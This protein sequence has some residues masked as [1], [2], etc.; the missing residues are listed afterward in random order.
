[1]NIF[2]LVNMNENNI[3]GLFTANHEKICA[4]ENL[5]GKED[6]LNVYSVQFYD[7]GISRILKKFRKKK[8][9]VNNGPSFEIDGRIYRKEYLKVDMAAR[10]I[11][12]QDDD[13]KKYEPF[14]KAHEKEIEACDLVVAQWGYPHGRL[15]YHIGKKFNKPYFVQYYGSDI[16][17]NPFRD[18]NVRKKVVEVLDNAANNFFVSDV[19]RKTANQL[20]WNKDN[21]SLTKNGVN[22]DKFFDIGQEKKDQ[23]KEK[24]GIEKGDTVIG[25]VGSLTEVKRSDK[26]AE[27]FLGVDRVKRCKYLLVGGGDMKEL[28]ESQVDEAGLDCIFTGNVSIEEVNE[29]LNIMD[30]MVLPSR[31]EGFGSVIVE[32]NSLGVLAIG[33]GSGGIPEVIGDDEYIVE[34][35]KDFEDRY[36]KKILAAIEE[37]WDKEALKKRTRLEYGWERIARID[38]DLIRNYMERESNQNRGE[39]KDEK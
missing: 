32:A 24:L 22:F 13:Y 8:I 2:Y 9:F 16:H 17:T 11:E 20:G 7:V 26:L 29:Y 21:Y 28:V 31:R 18:S 12:K 19:L 23:L 4:L 1:M 15:A 39:F 25:Y 5:I 10:R 38:L 30:I 14:I 27:I 36:A 35:G 34:E 3:K 33:A 6:I 37:G